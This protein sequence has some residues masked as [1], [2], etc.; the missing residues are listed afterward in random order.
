MKKGA[1]GMLMASGWLLWTGQAMAQSGPPDFLRGTPAGFGAGLVVGSPSG[2]SLA[3]RMPGSTMV[4]AAVGW[5]LQENTL[6]AN[7]DYVFDLT[8][9]Q[10]DSTPDI[11]WPVYMGAGGRVRMGVDDAGLGARVPV[12]IRME[13]HDLKLDVYMELAPFV[14]LVPYTDAGLDFNL[15]VRFY[16]G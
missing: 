12:G 5:S 7:V 6:S 14:M 2:L 13:P 9:I 11:S 16:F 15:G 10:Q 1:L 4:Q 3:W 8:T